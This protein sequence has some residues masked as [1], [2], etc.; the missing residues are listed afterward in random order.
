[1]SGSPLLRM[2][3]ATPPAFDLLVAPQQAQGAALPGEQLFRGQRD[4]VHVEQR[5]FSIPRLYLEL[6]ARSRRLG[7]KDL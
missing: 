2:P 5:A 3:V 1:M 7:G 4:A 6:L